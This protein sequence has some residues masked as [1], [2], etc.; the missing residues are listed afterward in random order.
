MRFLADMEKRPLSDTHP[1][2]ERMLIERYRQMSAQEK[3][4]R[5]CEMNRTAKYLALLEIRR[6]HPNADD[7][8][9]RMRLFSRWLSPALMLKVYGWDV[10][11][12]GY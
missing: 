7:H 9:C 10:E 12:E 8:E 11:K 3:L 5:L 1:A 4:E 6:R 2:I